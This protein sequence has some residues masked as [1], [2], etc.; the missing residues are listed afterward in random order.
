[1]CSKELFL[2]FIARGSTGCE[3]ARI[4]NLNRQFGKLDWILN[5]IHGVPSIEE[6]RS[7][8]QEIFESKAETI[9]CLHTLLLPDLISEVEVALFARQL[10]ATSL[11][12]IDESDFS[13]GPLFENSSDTRTSFVGIP[14]RANL[15]DGQFGWPIIVSPLEWMSPG[16]RSPVTALIIKP[17]FL[18]SNLTTPQNQIGIDDIDLGLSSGQF[19]KILATTHEDV[20]L[21]R[22]GYNQKLFR[23]RSCLVLPKQLWSESAE[24]PV[25][26]CPSQK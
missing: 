24:W 22:S 16:R 3:F 2:N 18:K 23:A 4:A 25:S 17:G 9:D 15:A 26:S 13:E 11:F 7:L 19:D 6:L 20:V 8:Y 14:I 5:E 1:M 12:W 10:L 21:N